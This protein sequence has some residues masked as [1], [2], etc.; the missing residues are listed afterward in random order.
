MSIYAV[1]D[2]HG[3]YDEFV[4]A[5]KESGFKPNS[6]DDLLVV[7]GDVFDRGPQNAECLHLLSNLSNVI[8]IR[9]NHEYLLLDLLSRGYY[10]AHDKHNGTQETVLQLADYFNLNSKTFDSACIE[11]SQILNKNWFNKF[12]DYYETDKYVFVHGYIPDD[13][14]WRN[15]NWPEASWSCG[16]TSFIS[17]TEDRID[18]KT[19]ICGHWHCSYAHHIFERTPEFGE[20]ANFEPYIGE[21]F[22]S[23]DGCTALTHK[24]NVIKLD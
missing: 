23:I 5:L 18:G 11:L 2:I 16:V 17:E 14:Y 6:K 20:G 3:F 8:L 7:C 21:H 1:S 12:V 22:I 4:D 24:V 15:G 9:G 10:K 19:L 13:K